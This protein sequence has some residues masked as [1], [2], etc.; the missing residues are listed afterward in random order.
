MTAGDVSASTMSPLSPM[1]PTPSRDAA[2]EGVGLLEGPRQVALKARKS[3]FNL[4]RKVEQ[5]LVSMDGVDFSAEDHSAVAL[6][7]EQHALMAKRG[8]V[9]S[10]FLHWRGRAFQLKVGRRSARAVAQAHNLYVAR[11]VFR[12]WFA[13]AVVHVRT[14]IL[15]TTCDLTVCVARWLYGTSPAH[16]WLGLGS[17]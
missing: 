15:G 11:I 9:L 7:L 16:A 12:E 10:C 8:L 13:L 1:W 4:L 14:A 5:N 3:V 6:V 17:G 2:E